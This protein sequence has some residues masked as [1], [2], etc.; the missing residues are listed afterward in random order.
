MEMSQ[1]DPPIF[2]SRIDGP[3]DL[4]GLSVEEL[5]ELC[6]ELRAFVW[7]TITQVGG[8]LSA[9]L[10][11]VELTV[12]LHYLYDA[13]RDRILWDVGHQ[14]YIH[15]VLTGRRDALSTIRQMG[16][17][18]GFCKRSESPYDAFGAGHASTAIS[19][20]L[21]VATA[22][23]LAGDDYH[24]VAV[25][26]DGGLTGGLA[27]EGLNNAGAAG[28]RLVVILNDNK[29]SISPNVGAL[30]RYLT[31]MIASP[32]FNRAK[33]DVWRLSEHFPKT[34][35]FRQMVRR[36]EESLKGLLVP[37]LLFEDLGFRYL[38]PIDGH[39]LRELIS[40][41]ERVKMM[42]GPILLH[43]LTTKGKGVALAEH[44]PLKYHGVKGLVRTNGKL[45]P[46]APKPTYTDVFGRLIP[47]LAA[48]DERVVAVTA[49]MSEGTG[50]VRMGE[51]Q[52]KRLFDVG[53][54][55]AH[56]VTFCAGMATA[57]RRPIAAI[58]STFLQRAYDQILH[59]VALQHLPVV[60]CL[61]RAG[62]VGEDGP[63]HHGCFDLS[64]LSCV[65]EM[66]VA[67]PKDAREMCDLIHTALAQ[68][69]GPF[70]I[71]YPR[72]T[73]PDEITL[74]EI[75]RI[76]L[77]TVPI[78]SWERLRAGTDTVLLAVGSMVPAAMECAERLDR[79]GNS[80]GVVNC[81]FVKPLDETML[82]SILGGALRV[83]TLEEGSVWGG[84][85]SHVARLIEE[86]GS[87]TRLLTIGLPDSFVEHGKRSLLLDR[88][89]LS[90]ARVHA[91][92]EAWL[93]ATQDAPSAPV[94]S[95]ASPATT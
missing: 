15:K 53:I 52:P 85:G 45:E 83:V 23:D 65:P 92:I 47:R 51:L 68:E 94:P 66:T 1:P 26:G 13:P 36:I 67:A 73:I 30:S 61:D 12:A 79:P 27:Y 84:F 24:V 91:R 35:L 32:R 87:S 49:A 62:L 37:G 55:E 90:A 59:D 8:H 25:V 21:G 6:G 39:N 44:D 50:L 3:A 42:D 60:F 81:R 77:T 64:Y 16:G 28:R 69:R 82:R 46:P 70:A 19:A 29:M 34:K 7:D 40:V 86:W 31:N 43:V 18:S 22:R 48:A 72:D 71:R 63:T 41:L 9:S 58:Y 93:A 54:A 75:E 38:G 11:V 76:P 4:K 80:V 20:A 5:N 56:A 14:S 33:A 74:D 95:P 57:G 88:A 10:G 89:G 17:I 2:L 78:G